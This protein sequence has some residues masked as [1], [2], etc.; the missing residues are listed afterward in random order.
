MPLLESSTHV[1]GDKS[2]SSLEIQEDRTMKKN[3]HIF[4]RAPLSSNSPSW[5]TDSSHLS[6]EKNGQDTYGWY[7]FVEDYSCTARKRRSIDVD[8]W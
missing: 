2:N 1:K 5:S 7:V 3:T 4:Y 6:N 8:T